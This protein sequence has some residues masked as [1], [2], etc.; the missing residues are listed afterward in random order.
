MDENNQSMMVESANPDM[1]WLQ[2]IDYLATQSKMMKKEYI[3]RKLAN[4]PFTWNDLNDM[5]K[6]IHSDLDVIMSGIEN[7]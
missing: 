4:K 7:A 6:K 2:N 5:N 3:R 1:L